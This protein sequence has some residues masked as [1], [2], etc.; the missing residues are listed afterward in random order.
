MAD[1]K[2]ECSKIEIEPAEN[3]GFS[4]RKF[5]WQKE[6]TGKLGG[7]MP[8]M[9]PKTYAFSTL[10]DLSSFLHSSFSSGDK[11]GRVVQRQ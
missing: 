4:V 6:S 10:E 2:H 5:Y 7:V 1:G 11:K 3:G 8:Y 9:E